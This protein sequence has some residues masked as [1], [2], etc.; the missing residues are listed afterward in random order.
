MFKPIGQKIIQL[1]RV[2][3]TNNY[4]AILI[5]EGKGQHGTV[6]LADIQTAGRGQRGTE[7]QSKAGENILMSLILETDNLSASDQFVISELAALSLVTLLRK[8]GIFSTIKW[9]NDILV[10]DRKIAGILI[11]N[12]LHGTMVS[13]SIIGIGL[14][15]NQIEFGELNATSVRIEL[16]EFIAVRDVLMSWIHSF[17]EE[18]NFYNSFGRDKVEERYLERLYGRDVLVEMEDDYGPFTGR[19]HGIEKSGKLRVEKGKQLFSYDLKELRFI[20]QNRS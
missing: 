1:E 2:D 15:I 7:W 5:S 9:P 17:N 16:G 3:S 13:K 14:N 4:A 19:V 6:I 8:I 10:K 20:F 12:Q 11:E 18:W